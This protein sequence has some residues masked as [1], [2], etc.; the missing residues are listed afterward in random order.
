MIWNQCETFQYHQVFQVIVQKKVQIKFVFFPDC[1]YFYFYYS[2]TYLHTYC[3]DR[4]LEWRRNLPLKHW[5]WNRNLTK[6][7]MQERGP[8][9][10]AG[11]ERERAEWEGLGSSNLATPVWAFTVQL[12]A[13]VLVW[14]SGKETFINKITKLQIPEFGNFSWMWMFLNCSS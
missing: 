6:L 4:I 9:A 1:M 12:C 14:R 3:N 2:I 8:S 10:A 13:N 7:T 5:S 11:E